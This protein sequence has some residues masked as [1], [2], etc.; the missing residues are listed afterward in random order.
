MVRLKR[1]RDL[2]EE[3]P[4]PQEFRHKRADKFPEY[5][6]EEEDQ[7]PE[8]EQVKP[9][10]S[11]REALAPEDAAAEVI[12]QAYDYGDFDLYV[13]MFSAAF[14]ILVLRER[15]KESSGLQRK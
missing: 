15:Q 4:R 8:T 6:K 12:E 14:E 9:R 3:A 11:S 1:I 7:E 2:E 10:K 5:P 13:Q